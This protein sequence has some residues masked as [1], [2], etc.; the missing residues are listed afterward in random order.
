MV[1]IGSSVTS[2]GSE[3]FKENR[4]TSV[5]I[6]D[7]VS[8][9]GDRAFLQAQSDGVHGRSYRITSITI[10]TNVTM[11]GNTF[12]GSFYY[13]ENE[14]KLIENV[15]N[16]FQNYYIKNSRKAGIYTLITS[17]SIFMPGQWFYGEP[18]AAKK[19]D[20]KNNVAV[21]IT[22]GLLGAGAIVG[23]IFLIPAAMKDTE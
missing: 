9:I 17:S 18:E 23:L 15:D 7:N 22:C 5:I 3:A 4:I 10:G 20:R 11:E 12:G 16:S 19:K 2:I 6:P 13:N 14:R 21:W 8:F 1:T